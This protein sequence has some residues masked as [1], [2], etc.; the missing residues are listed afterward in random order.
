MKEKM[1][2]DNPTIGLLLCKDKNNIVAEYTLR[3]M[4]K[5]MGVSSY[6]IKDVLPKDLENSLPSLN[7]LIE[8]INEEKINEDD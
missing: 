6:R 2:N 4:N 8:T 5:P 7:A 3:D 1:N